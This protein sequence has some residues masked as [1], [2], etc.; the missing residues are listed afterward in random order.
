M[1]SMASLQRRVH[2]RQLLVQR[3]DLVADLAHVRLQRLRPRRACPSRISWPICFEPVLRSARSAS[4]RVRIARRRSS[5][6]S[7]CA[8]GASSAPSVSIAA[9]HLVPVLAHEF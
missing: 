1:R 4:T 3:L 5:S 8:T 9:E 7:A 2:L 6:A